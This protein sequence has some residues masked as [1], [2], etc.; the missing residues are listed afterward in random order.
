MKFTCSV[1]SETE[2]GIIH[3]ESLEILANV[4]AKFL[5]EKALNILA[6][7]GAKV[8]R[9]TKIATIPKEMVDQALDTTPKSFVLGARNP[10][11]DYAM[12]S[13]YT[14]YILDGAATF[15]N[16]FKSG[17]RRYAVLEDLKSSFR[18]FEE[19]ELAAL[20]WPNVAVNDFP[21]NSMGIRTFLAAFEHTSMHVQHE[22][23]HPAEVPYLVEALTA[24]LGSE[25][26][27]KARKICSGI[28]C[29]IPP[30]VHDD[31]MADAYL[32]AIQFHFP[33]TVLPMPA[34]GT[35][36]PASLYS[37]I[38]VANAE[39]LSAFVLFQMANPG[40]PMIYGTAVG[41]VDFA[42][43]GF[44]V[45]S[46]EMALMN[47]AL[48]EMARFY[49]LPN[50]QAACSSDAKAP[51]S[52][53]I[54]EKVITNLPAVL[55]GADLIVGMG[56]VETAN[57]LVLEQI[58]VDH[59]IAMMC[60]RIKDGVDISPAKNYMGDVAKAGPAGHYLNFDSTLKA[61]RSDEF[62]TP[63]LGDRSTFEEWEASGRPEIYSRARTKVEEILATPQ[64]YPLPEKI[65]AKFETM[66]KQAD[67]EL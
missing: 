15:A 61:C 8:D 37:N 5:S 42:R 14:G 21:S 47:S 50:T 13:S 44:L 29:T 28:Y 10:E 9:E 31:A 43:A 57:L 6:A 62:F 39:A 17:E 32:E 2:K 53:A 49:G 12:P 38:S 3:T 18:I 23:L 54:M 22:L 24:I 16:D 1:L 11:H 30:L 55:G 34:C 41:N 35:T 63:V 33:I 66:M 65:C 67:D 40:T 19:L 60:K 58:L 4:G 27:I 59:E 52:Q 25:D 56:E 48:C 20:V 64:K 51:G 7:N 45:G 26:Q 46:P 36:G